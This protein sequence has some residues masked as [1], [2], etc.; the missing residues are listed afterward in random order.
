MSSITFKNPGK[1]YTIAVMERFYT[2]IDELLDQAVVKLG[3]KSR[4]KLIQHYGIDWS[5][6]SRYRREGRPYSDEQLK[7]VAAALDDSAGVTYERLLAWRDMSS[8]SGSEIAAMMDE[9][10]D[11]LSDE[12]LVAVVEKANKRILENQPVLK[13]R[14]S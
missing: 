10:V 1:Y 3:F 9:A 11:L 2:K 7:A 8:K 6:I 5:N 14:S 4:N 13:K 12:E